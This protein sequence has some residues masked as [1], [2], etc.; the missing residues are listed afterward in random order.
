MANNSLDIYGSEAKRLL[1][2]YLADNTDAQSRVAPYFP[3]GTPLALQQAQLVVALESGSE[4]WVKFYAK[5]EQRDQEIT[6]LMT[7]L[8]GIVT[9]AFELARE[10]VSPRNICFKHSSMKPVQGNASRRLVPI[11]RCYKRRWMALSS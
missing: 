2:F 11:S 5:T 6:V 4:S 1:K 3:D 7:D 9:T 8:K 10:L